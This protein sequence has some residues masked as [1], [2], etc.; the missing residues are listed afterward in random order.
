M[1]WLETFRTGING[2]RSH[3]L[4]SV[5]TVLGICIG[6]TAVILTVGLGEG[7]QNQV[8]SEITALGTNVLTISPGSSTSSAGIREALGTASTLNLSDTQALSS[9]VV[10]PDIK[11]VAPITQSSETLTASSTTWTTTVQ[12]STPEWL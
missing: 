2:I 6:I 5:L 3:R 7:A 11:A 4:R 8:T 12:G 1:S 9:P 10:A